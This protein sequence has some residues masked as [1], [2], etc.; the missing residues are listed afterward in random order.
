MLQYSKCDKIK[1]VKKEEKNSL[2]DLSHCD[3]TQKIKLIQLKN[4]NCDKTQ[5]L[6][7]KQNSKT[8]TVTKF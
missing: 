1:I 5:Y 2:L 8:Q 6:K 3:K 7:L 4:P